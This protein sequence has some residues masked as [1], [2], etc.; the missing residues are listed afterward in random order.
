[1]PIRTLTEVL[2]SMSLHSLDKSKMSD[3]AYEDSIEKYFQSG[4]SLIALEQQSRKDYGQLFSFARV[5]N[6]DG[7]NNIS[8]NTTDGTGVSVYN[9][10]RGEIF[11][12]DY[13]EE[14]LGFHSSEVNFFGK[15]FSKDVWFDRMGINTKPIP[16]HIYIKAKPGLINTYRMPGSIFVGYPQKD[17]AYSG[18]NFDYDSIIDSPLV[19]IGQNTIVSSLPV[20]VLGDSNKWHIEYDGAPTYADENLVDESGNALGSKQNSASD[21]RVGNKGIS[22]NYDNIFDLNMSQVDLRK[23]GSACNNC[24]A[25]AAPVINSTLI[26]ESGSGKYL[27]TQDLP[28]IRR[29][30]RS[31][32]KNDFYSSDDSIEMSNGSM[33]VDQFINTSDSY[34]ANDPKLI[35]TEELNLLEI[36]G[37][38]ELPPLADGSFT[39][40]E[41]IDRYLKPAYTTGAEYLTGYKTDDEFKL[42][43]THSGYD[44]LNS[45]YYNF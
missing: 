9:N 25:V 44:F 17:F 43:Y 35:R 28:E 18:E 26:Y 13:D 33:D 31:G 6:F 5:N 38:S 24:R 27:S 42:G 19:Y 39:A 40:D 23:A 32:W 45:S 30:W 20:Y 37:Q 22:L 11:G 12:L 29:Y 4:Y 36:F 21:Y 8:L 2:H 7:A 10:Q 15:G 1:M 14:N 41:I 16:D 34:T 3:K